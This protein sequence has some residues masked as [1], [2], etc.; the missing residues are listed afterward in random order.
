MQRRCCWP[1][2]RLERALAQA[3]PSL[4]PRAR[5]GAATTRRSRSSSR[6]VAHAVD[7]RAVGDVVVDRLRERIPALEHHSDALAQR[8][9]VHADARRRRRRRA[10]SPSWRTPGIRSFSRLIE[11]RK[12]DL[13]QPDGPMSAV[14]ARG[15]IASV[16]RRTAPASSRTRTRTCERRSRPRVSVGAGAARRLPRVGTP[17]SEPPGDVGSVR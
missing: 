2:D 15:R 14:I 10:R 9:D 12:V 17:S 11:R 3:G 1:P 7:A 6:A 16:D 5:R 4:R 13:P 8:D